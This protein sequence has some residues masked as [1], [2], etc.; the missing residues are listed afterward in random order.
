MR[1]F[2]S[3]LLS[4][5]GLVWTGQAGFA[6][7]IVG[8]DETIVKPSGNSF[9]IDGGA[10]SGNNL[11]HSF[12]QF[13]LASD[14]TV[15]FLANP[16]IINI[17]ARVTGGNASFLD[18]NLVIKGG[19]PSFYLMNPAGVIFGPNF[20]FP[21]GLPLT[22]TTA[23]GVMFDSQWWSAIGTNDYPA[24]TKEP[25]AF[26]LT[27]AQP[28]AII[29]R[30]ASGDTPLTLIAGTVI[31]PADATATAGNIT[32]AAVPSDRFVRITSA[33]N[34]LGLDI[35]PFAVGESR[36]NAVSNPIPSLAQL[37][38]GPGPSGG[39]VGDATGLR[40]NV[41]GTVLLSGASLNVGDVYAGNLTAQGV[42]IGA[43]GNV[44]VSTIEAQ[45]AGVQVIAGNHFRATSS[46][47]YDNIRD[48]LSS[49]VSSVH[50]SIAVFD[51]DSL[52]PG[53]VSI[54]HGRGSSLNVSTTGA[55][56]SGNAV[57]ILGGR[58]TSTLIPVDISGTVNAIV[59]PP[60]SG[61][62]AGLAIAYANQTFG[63]IGPVPGATITVTMD[64]QPFTAEPPIERGAE[65]P[66]SQSLE[67]PLVNDRISANRHCAATPSSGAK[68]TIVAMRSSSSTAGSGNCATDSDDVAILRI[69][70]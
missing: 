68:G 55:Q 10:V 13:G 61:D 37:I 16:Q 9:D 35:R 64:S 15:K 58:T 28:A 22:A 53:T 62:A 36:P 33:G 29:N 1:F 38:T 65:P 44:T 47:I 31:S 7:S 23:N 6:Q 43:P 70:E 27:I 52:S 46:R 18:G 14:Q 49:S 32:M 19:T 8:Q 4:I 67:S 5:F 48:G 24:L 30:W 21:T 60:N 54:T 57:F 11:F 39:T 34:L 50:A 63:N 3:F 2:A 56:A 40:V 25:V 20:Q 41:D 59:V 69:L 66:A 26:G 42:L 51:P 17:F 12:T 45:D